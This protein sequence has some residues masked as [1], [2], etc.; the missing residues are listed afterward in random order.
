MNRLYLAIWLTCGWISAQDLSRDLGSQTGTVELYFVSAAGHR[1]RNPKEL[2]IISLKTGK[3]VPYKLEQDYVHL[4]YGRYRAEAHFRGA[5]LVERAFTVE[6]PRQ[7]VSFCFFVAPIEFGMETNVV[8]G[9]LSQQGLA[10]R[11]VWIRAL[12]PFDNNVQEVPASSVT[13][14]F[15]FDNLRA[16]KYMILAI[17]PEGVCQFATASFYFGHEYVDLDLHW[18]DWK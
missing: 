16:G 5:Y 10:K 9:R 13:G 3:D 1:M 2:R 15:Y 11:C 4:P 12:S 8:R 14:D 17:G 7:I 18:V 6:R